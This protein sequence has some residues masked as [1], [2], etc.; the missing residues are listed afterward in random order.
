MTGGLSAEAGIF[1]RHCSESAGSR[2]EPVAPLLPAV[3]RADNPAARCSGFIPG[4]DAS[5][6]EARPVLL[7]WNVALG[8]D[9]H[10]VWSPVQGQLGR[11]LLH[12]VP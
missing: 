9:Y 1:S 3:T 2:G 10:N 5:Q 11:P 12:L 6:E 8:D 7:R 4:P